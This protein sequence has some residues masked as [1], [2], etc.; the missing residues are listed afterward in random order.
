MNIKETCTSAHSNLNPSSPTY[1]VRHRLEASHQTAHNHPELLH[2][3][4]ESEQPHE[5]QHPQGRNSPAPNAGQSKAADHNHEVEGVEGPV[6]NVRE[7]TVRVVA[8]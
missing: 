6:F 1:N 8:L 5:P 7:I 3:L 4:D 2:P